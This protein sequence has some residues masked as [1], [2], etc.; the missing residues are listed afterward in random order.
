MKTKRA[1]LF[2]ATFVLA[3][4]AACGVWLHIQKQQYARNRALI[5]ALIHEDTK[6][7]L[8]LVNAGA[9]PNTR[10][11]LPPAFSLRFLMDRWLHH[12]PPPANDSPTAFLLA[13][14]M[15]NDPTTNYPIFPVTPG[16]NLPLLQAMLARGANVNAKG[17]GHHAALHCAVVGDNWRA[18]GLLLQY[19][20]DVN[21][22]NAWNITPLLYAAR[23]DYAYIEHPLLTH[24][25]NPNV[26]DGLGGTALHH[27]L[28]SCAPQNIIPE[29]MAH[30][31]NPDLRDKYGRTPLQLAH[32]I[33]RPDLVRLMERRRRR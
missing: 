1:L 24:G 11:T 4:C 8:E 15:R 26:Q 33:N 25:A 9:D 16:E 20:A 10:C 18:I 21:V 19:G 3:M 31:A 17:I 14:G 12:A 22:R 23:K 5:D 2:T 7:A 27:A 13:C 6:T 32:N 29:L 28:S 30:G